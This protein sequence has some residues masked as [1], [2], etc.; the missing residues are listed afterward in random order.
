M[1]EEIF[2]SYIEIGKIVNTH[3]LRGHLKVEPWCDGIEVYDFL[4]YIYVNNKKLEIEDVKQHKSHFLLKLKG[5]DKIEDAEL[6]K[7]LTVMADEADMPELEDGVFYI[8]DLIGLD[9]YEDEKYIGKIVDWIETGSKNV[10]VIKR[11]KGRDVLIPAIDDIIKN[12][13][14]E[15]NIMSVKL[16]EGLINDEN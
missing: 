9:V 7:G 2:M 5:I 3:G 12:I 16:M 10:Y 15:N 14:I 11:Q 4:S 8:R 13:D 6:F 1:M